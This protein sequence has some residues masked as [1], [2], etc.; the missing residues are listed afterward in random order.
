MPSKNVI[1]V[2]IKLGQLT[3]ARK[4]RICKLLLYFSFKVLYIFPIYVE[5]F[6]DYL[7]EKNRT[8][9]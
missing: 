2:Q 7:N 4:V 6:P 9:M 1:K 8:I 5:F 3:K